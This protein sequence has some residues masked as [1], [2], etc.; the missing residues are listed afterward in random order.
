MKTYRYSRL[1]ETQAKKAKKAAIFYI[2]TSIIVI[3]LLFFYGINYSSKITEIVLNAI[4]KKSTTLGQ[5]TLPPASPKIFDLDEFTNEKNYTISGTSE[6]GSEIT[7]F[8][9]QNE[10]KILTNASGIFQTSVTLRDGE[11]KIYAK[12]TDESGNQSLESSII[13]ITLDTNPPLLTLTE[14]NQKTFI[15]NDNKKIKIKGETEEG[16]QIHINDNFV[17]LNS[18]NTFEFEMT[19]SEGDNEIVIIATDKANNQTEIINNFIW[20]P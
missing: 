9:N 11:N 3:L 1:A 20:Q 17:F 7:I 13:I 12:A 6:A 2:I 18:N 10:E 19:L 5:D 14:P 4:G 8:V 15:G 16:A